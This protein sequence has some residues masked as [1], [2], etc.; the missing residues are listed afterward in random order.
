MVDLHHT[1]DAESKEEESLKESPLPSSDVN[2]QNVV[3][4]PVHSVPESP[5]QND[6]TAVNGQIADFTEP[7]GRPCCMGLFMF[8]VPSRMN[9]DVVC[10]LLIYHFLS[11]R[12]YIFAHMYRRA[13]K[14]DLVSNTQTSIV[15]TITNLPYIVYIFSSS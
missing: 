1:T 12:V 9:C 3:D 5:S 13:D 8:N 4:N 11:S 14:Y 6:G 2:T 15:G 7:A 10:H